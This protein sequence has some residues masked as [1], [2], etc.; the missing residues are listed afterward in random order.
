MISF[1]SVR[2]KMPLRL[3]QYSEKSLAVYGDITNPQH[4]T[5][6]ESLK[7]LHNANLKEGPGY[8]F[9]LKHK[10][11]LEAYIGSKVVQGVPT[12][13]A[14][15]KLLKLKPAEKL[16]HAEKLEPVIPIVRLTQSTAPTQLDRIERMLEE[17]LNAV[18]NS[19]K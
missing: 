5:F 15:V 18:K 11:T 4:V 12:S 6:L 3:V 9:P 1:L 10:D 8:I 13:S 19:K 17:L 7:G 16:E 2:K 14:P